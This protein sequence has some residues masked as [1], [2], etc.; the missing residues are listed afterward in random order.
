MTK[1]GG[2]MRNKNS[3]IL[4][5]ILGGWF[6]LHRYLD[7]KIVSGLIYT[8]TFGVFGIGWL[9]DVY[10]ALT[11]SN[12]SKAYNYDAFFVFYPIQCSIG[13]QN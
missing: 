3:R 8:F 5:T 9:I 2:L 1:E 4:I 7:R 12:L 11:I 6:G 13:V 10:H